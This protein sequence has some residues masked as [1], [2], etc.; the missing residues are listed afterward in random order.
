MLLNLYCGDGSTSVASRHS[1]MSM[2]ACFALVLNS[3]VTSFLGV[4]PVIHGL[5]ILFHLLLVDL[6]ASVAEAILRLVKTS[7]LAWIRG[8]R[9]FAHDSTMMWALAP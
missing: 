2:F 3:S 8:G 1:F 4:M 9:A 6:C 5:G 7:D